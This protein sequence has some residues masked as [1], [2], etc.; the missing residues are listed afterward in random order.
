MIELYVTGQSMKLYTPVIA[1]DTL[2]YLTAKVYFT[3]EEWDGYAKWLHFRQGEGLDATVYDLALNEDG[4]ITEAQ[5]LNL[6]VG[7][8]EIYLTGTKD[9][10][11]LT[12][13]A[14][15]L[16]VKESG[17]IDAP[18]HPMPLSVAEQVDSK[19]TTALTMIQALKAR[20]D[21]GDFDG[22]DGKSLVIAGF[23]DTAA[24]LRE[25]VPFP[26]K[27]E[28]YG[29]GTAAPYDIYVWD[30]V[31][32]RWRNAGSFLSAKGDKGETGDTG[33]TFVPTVDA[34]GNISWTN[35][36]GLDNPVTRNITGP[37]GPAGAAGANG[38]SPYE[39]AVDAGYTGTEATFYAAL[40]SIPYHN[41][42]HLPDGVDPITVKT[43]N[44][45][46]AAVTL[47]KLAA[48]SVNRSKI[49]DGSVTDI[50]T[51]TI[52]TTWTG[53]AAPYTQTVTVE[54]LTAADHPVIDI[55]PSDTYA[56]AEK[57]MDAWADIYRMVAGDG[58][59]TIYAGAVTDTAVPIQILCVRK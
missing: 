17:L 35:N 41:A 14:L 13:V 40:V 5:E 8:W 50:Y 59:L 32:E 53:E 15:I 42:R 27:G 38:M 51:A 48:G 45:E 21:A 29:V 52:G 9:E 54:G 22:A 1:A 44:I 24:D 36:A 4:E 31:N 19:A 12:T 20:A 49:L 30:A 18:L 34:N 23:Y 33:A 3:D 26:E 55:V 56:V 10:A 57:Q 7:E 16:T 2:H 43:G 11:R 39:A 37:A 28:A 6:T 25:A 58:V 47:E 46:N